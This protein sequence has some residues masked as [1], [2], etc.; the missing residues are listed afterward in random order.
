MATTKKISNI[1]DEIDIKLFL[2]IAKRSFLYIAIF[3]AIALIGQ[4]LYLRYAR[5]IYQTSAT[6]QISSNEENV[7]K[8]LETESMGLEQQN[9]IE[10][11]RELIS[12]PVFLERAFSS[13]PLAISYYQEG[14]IMSSE[15]YKTAPF[16]ITADVKVPSIYGIPIYVN[17]ISKDRYELS[18]THGG[19]QKYTK[20]FAISG[21]ASIPEADI[22]LKITNSNKID[23]KN[24]I[25]NQNSY[26]FIINN[27]NGIVYN[28]ASELTITTISEAAKTI[29]I[30]IKDQNAIKASDLVNAIV[31]TYRTYGVEKKAEST[32]SVLE[33]ID[34]QLQQVY[35]TLFKSEMDLE[36]FKK[37]NRLDSTQME[38]LPSIYSRVN[39]F[40]DQLIELELQENLL[41]QV[42]NSIKE[43]DLDI[44][45]M[46]AT[47]AGSEFEGSVSNFLESLQELLLKKEKL[48]YQVTKNS[49][50]IEEINYQIEIQKKLLAECIT[51]LKANLTSRKA[52]IN[53]YLDSYKNTAFSSKENYNALELSRLQR[54]YNINEQF[55]NKLIEKK[56]EYQIA[57]AGYVSQI[58][59]LDKS[60]VPNDPI[61]P[62]RRLIF[63]GSLLFA[64]FI[65]IGLILIRYL[66][67]N[68]ITNINDIIKYTDAPILGIIPKYRREIPVSQLIVD[69]KPKSLIA[70]SLRSIRTNLQF[71]NNDPGPKVIAITSTISGEGKTFVSINLAGI[72]AF[73]DKKVIVIDLDLRKPKI[74]KGFGVENRKGVSTILMN[75]DS[76]KECIQHST[77]PNLDFLTAGPVPPNPSELMLTKRMEQ[78]IDLLKN[79]Y[80]YV[81][82]DNPPIG[83]VTDGM[84]NMLIADYPIYVFKATHSKRMF[85]QNVD[86][87]INE[88][89]IKRLAIV[90]NAV[91]PQYSG[92]NYGKGN[93]YGPGYGAGYGYGYG[94]AYGYG[95]GYY[96]DDHLH[97]IKKKFILD[98][99]SD[100]IW[101][102]I[103]RRN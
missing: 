96:D 2:Y 92:Y 95:Y 89:G 60:T 78:M 51:T 100:F 83:L 25:L 76:E 44:Y 69:K 65:S 79:N 34:K 9:D 55:Y 28:Y 70:E 90:L 41:T 93:S 3:L 57:K 30:S 75:M 7:N 63:F 4:F 73:S 49:G 40:D 11:A 91:E 38:P 19:S 26:F 43:K 77:V 31:D 58:V 68:E 66:F 1:N 97:P 103:L 17:F 8:I 56:A 98:R 16:E 81:I 18:Y 59:V 87:L 50:Q 22:K 15:Q 88:S 53:K 72:I 13:L 32:N 36:S 84:R 71:V 20:D 99:I 80:D 5:P 29:Q 48:L 42:Q 82:I 27:P 85:V 67:Y 45:K 12:S 46:I 35:D 94:Y 54:M 33:F 21:K 102:K 10:K 52:T 64:I 39:D 74:H 24:G 23:F 14:T 37:E 101:K 47:V 62:R 86:R 61:S 6:V